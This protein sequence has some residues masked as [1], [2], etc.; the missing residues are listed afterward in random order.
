VI[1]PFFEICGGP[2]P[3]LR[4]PRNAW[5]VLQREDI[6]TLDQLRAVIPRID[7][8]R[9]VGPKTAQIIQ[10]ELIRVAPSEEPTDL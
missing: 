5:A 3:G 8:L 9:D 4:L 2:I 6:R 10:D 1:S 7:C